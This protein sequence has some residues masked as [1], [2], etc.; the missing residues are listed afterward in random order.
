ME[1]LNIDPWGCILKSNEKSIVTGG[2]RRVQNG[3]DPSMEE[4]ADEKKE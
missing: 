4:A 2:S 3:Y 1:F